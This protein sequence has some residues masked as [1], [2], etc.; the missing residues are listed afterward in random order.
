MITAMPILSVTVLSSLL[1]WALWLQATG[2]TRKQRVQLQRIET[3]IEI[4]A[5]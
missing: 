3:G 2:R 5:A 4:A 1:A